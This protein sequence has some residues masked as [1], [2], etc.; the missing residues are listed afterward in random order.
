MRWLA[1]GDIHGCL[2]ALE[3]LAKAVPFE[4]ADGVV[5]LG[6][7]VDRGPDSYGVVEWLLQWGRGHRLVCLR[8]NH[9]ILM[10]EG[11][12]DRFALRPW[13]EV[14]GMATLESYRKDGS[15]MAV[16]PAHEEFLATCLP[17]LETETHL[18]VHASVDPARAM[19]DQDE[20][21]LFWKRADFTAPPHVSGKPVVCGH[22]ALRNGVPRSNGHLTCI[23]TFAYGGGWL[24][25]LDV[26]TGAYWQARESGEIRRGMLDE[27]S[28]RG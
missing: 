22:T 10:Q 9:E 27:P 23:D 14:G 3:V 28:I 16:P 4:A 6:D 21:T 1:V 8:G 24:T 11:L 19:S 5:T 7:H 13:L 18:F 20:E 25:A 26:R 17:W 2:G 15:A 12:R